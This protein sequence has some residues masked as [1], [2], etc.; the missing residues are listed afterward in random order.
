MKQRY[1]LRQECIRNLIILSKMLILCFR[2]KNVFSSLHVF[3]TIFTVVLTSLDEK[4]CLTQ[5]MPHSLG[6]FQCLKMTRFNATTFTTQ[7]KCCRIRSYRLNETSFA[8]TMHSWICVQLFRRQITTWS[9]YE[10][11]L[12]ITYTDRQSSRVSRLATGQLTRNN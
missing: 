9:E 12:I 6:L 2:L 4:M 7:M 5:R 1:A 11:V 3:W 8:N 10:N